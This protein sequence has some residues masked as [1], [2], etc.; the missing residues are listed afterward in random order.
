MYLNILEQLGL[1]FFAIR[2]SIVIKTVKYSK[3]HSNYTTDL[4]IFSI[5]PFLDDLPSYDDVLALSQSQGQQE[6]ARF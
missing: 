6:R 2:T 1:N 5:H 3:K 4:K